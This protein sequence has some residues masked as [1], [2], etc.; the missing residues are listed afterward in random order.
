MYFFI[1]FTKENINI[2]HLI[3]KKQTQIYINNNK[4][5]F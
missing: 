4:P 3:W 5:I 2:Q 1:I